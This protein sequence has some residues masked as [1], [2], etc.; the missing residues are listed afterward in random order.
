MGLGGREYKLRE[1]KNKLD[2]DL[3][4][5]RRSHWFPL[6]PPSHTHNIHLPNQATEVNLSR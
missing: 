1:A 5:D 3:D 2:S 6:L 4:E